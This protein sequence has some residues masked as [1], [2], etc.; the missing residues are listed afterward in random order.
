M[1]SDL[2]AEM[3]VRGIDGIVVFGDTTLADPDLMYVAGGVL[4][5]G[6]TYFKGLGRPPLLIVSNLDYGSAKRIGKVKRIQ[7]LTQWGYEKLLRRYGDRD[8]VF[9]PL[10]SRI[11]KE[12]GV[13]GKVVLLGRNDM[14]KG[15]QLADKLRRLGVKVVG[16]QAPTILESARDRKDKN[17]LEEIRSVGRRTAK[18][19]NEVL[20][21][22]Q[23]AKE[24]RGHLQIGKRRAT[25][26]VVKFMISSKLARQHLVAPE[27]TIFA[28]GSSGADPHNAGV[29]TEEIRKGKLIVFDIF[30]Q[31]ESGYWFD[32]TRSFVVGRADA[33]A[34]KL[35]ETV[36]EAQAASLDSLRA[37]VTGEA[38]MGLACKIIEHGGYR[39]VRQIFQGR[40]TGISS[41]FIHSLGHG[42][43]LTIGESPYLSFSRKDPL[44]SREV[45]TVE[46]G[47]YLPGYGGVRIEDTVAITSKGIENLT[48]VDKELELN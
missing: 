20:H 44:K 38:T 46:P 42:V 33:R 36:K 32:L 3:R 21:T 34:R 37:G 45:V 2:D 15:I 13:R 7:T 28:I 25:V 9:P 18:V 22:L 4:P 8:S 41:G 39:T 17:E 12:E 26:G 10:M 40:S 29:N 6:G 23:N 1:I 31:A 11:L 30:P 5:R 35:F 43:G 16:Q 48:Q 14:A 47:V 27:G 24:K 19:V